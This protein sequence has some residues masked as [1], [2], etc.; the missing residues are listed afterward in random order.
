MYVDQHRYSLSW[1]RTVLLNILIIGLY[2]LLGNASFYFARNISSPPLWAPGG[3]ALGLVIVFGLSQTILGLFVGMSVLALQRWN[4]DLTTFGFVLSNLLEV[5][6]AS[7]LL[8]SF[9]GGKYRFKSQKDIFGFILI[10]AILAPFVSSTLAVG[11]LYTGNLIPDSG[12]QTIWV[13]H[14]IN[15]CLGILVVTPLVLSFFSRDMRKVNGWEAIILYTTLAI[16]VDWSFSGPSIRKFLIIPLMTWSALRFGFRGISI[17]TIIVGFIAVWKSH[18]MGGLFERR[19]LDI[20]FLIIQFLIGALS[21]VGYFMAT[22]VEAQETANEKE[23]ELSIKDDALAILDQSLHKSPI[24]FALIDKDLKYIRVNE[25]L[26]KING[27][28]PNEHLGKTVAEI[29]PGLSDKVIP[30]IKDVLNTGR[31]HTNIPF[32]GFTPCNAQKFMAGILSYYPVR[33]PTTQEIF[34]VAFSF[35]DI[36]E[37]SKVQTLLTEN[38][39]RM[40]FAQEAGRI[41]AFEWNV[42]T[43]RILWT[44]ELEN[45]YE[46]SPGD[47]GGFYENWLVWIHPSDVAEFNLEINH[48]LLEEKE[49]N[50]EFRI[51]TSSDQIRWILARGRVLTENDGTKK[52]IGINIDITEQKATE[53]KLRLTEANLLHALSVRDEFMAIASHELKTPLTSLKLANQFFQRGMVKED[54]YNCKIATF[55]ERNC[56]QID[57][58][59]RLVDDMLDISR[60]RTG[61]FSLKKESCELSQMLNDIINRCKDQFESSGSGL[62]VIENM[63]AAKGEWDPLRI[64][65]VFTNIITNA[66]RY[67]QGKPIQISLKNHQESVRV[68]VKDQGLGIPKSDQDKIFRRYERGL[69]AR[70]VSG[71]GLGLFIS[72]QIIDAHGGSIMI[73][74]EVNQGATFIV[75]LPRT[76]LPIILKPEINDI[77]EA[78]S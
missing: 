53:Q 26:A 18:Q 77:I 13:T 33:H 75:D 60:I 48:V 62:P 25:A 9:G 78:E 74:S 54:G 20:D 17:G 34:A 5:I 65:Q 52:L 4:P 16:A 1:Q 76:C 63:E 19:S 49:L 57:R 42:E 8:K 36:T 43:N 66:I 7:V 29:V 50:Y 44:P 72:K 61:K 67:G 68:I 47:F 39:E 58:L 59:T 41:G 32:S 37:L 28:E 71:L 35:Q 40:R 3:L 38:Q 11:V 21:I 51:I 27:I 73:E 14:F 2:V 69:L 22:V 56:V 15:D 23:I 70:E 64:D 10:S 46:L 12:I 55:I 31:S 24:G 6:I 30:I 45:I